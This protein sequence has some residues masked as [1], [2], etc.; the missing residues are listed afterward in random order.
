MLN[1]EDLVSSSIKQ[2]ELSAKQLERLEILDKQGAISPA[3]VSDLKGQLMN[4]ELGIL[5]LSNQLESAKL[6][7]TQLMYIPYSKNIQLWSQQ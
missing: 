4:D 3:Q 5:N 6:A 2:K 1:S 7:L